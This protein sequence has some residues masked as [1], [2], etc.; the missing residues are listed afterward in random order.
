[1][2]SLSHQTSTPTL[3]DPSHPKYIHFP[4]PELSDSDGF[5]GHGGNLN[6]ETLLSAYQQGIFPWFNQNQ[7][8]LWWSPNPRMIIKTDE[9]HVS[10]SLKKCLR[11]SRFKVT[12]G[13]AFSDVIDAC[14]K[15]RQTHVVT[16]ESEEINQEINDGNEKENVQ[17]HT[18][19]TD[20]MKQA[21]IKLHHQGFAQSIECWQNEQLVGGLYGVTFAG[22]FFG[23]SMFSKVTNSSKIA[24]FHLCQFLKSQRVDWIDC[25][26]ESDHLLSLGAINIPRHEFLTKIKHQLSQQNTIDWQ[27][28]QPAITGKD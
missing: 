16:A 23:E 12:C 3:I 17:T 28:F 7:P 25:Q 15:P 21:Y 4:N 20:E 11:A 24:L 14:S 13:Q 27:T 18:W 10:K 6:V 8:L 19:I 26:V 2:I 22:M 5:I 1:L 9:M